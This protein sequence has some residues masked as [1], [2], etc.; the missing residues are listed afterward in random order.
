MCPAEVF[1]RY[2]FAANSGPQ[3]V[4][5]NNDAVVVG[6]DEGLTAITAMT[7][8][9][10]G[11]CA[12]FLV[13]GSVGTW[14]TGINDLDHVV[15]FYW[16]ATGNP[17]EP[18]LLRFH[19]FLRDA[20]GIVR[21]D[22]PGPHDVVFPTG[23][24]DVGQIVGYLYSD[25]QPDNSYVYHAFRYENGTY[26]IVDDPSGADVWLLGLNN[27]GQAVGIVGSDGVTGGQAFLLDNGVFLPLNVPTATTVSFQP[28]AINDHGQLVGN[29]AERDMTGRLTFHQ[30]MA[31]PD[32]QGRGQEMQHV[33]KGITRALAAIEKNVR[34]HIQSPRFHG[35]L[36]QFSPELDVDGAVV[37]RRGEQVLGRVH[38]EGKK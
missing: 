18:G 3:V 2:P 22:G 17:D 5:M 28:T 29:Y 23:L 12:F 21:L 10:D 8:T 7:Q 34:R 13:P 37:L 30:F 6:N 27:V 33:P 24:N 26:E 1:Q 31:T 20:G 9:P 19:G 11:T 4:G 36:Q 35:L 16:N 25:V 38:Q 32:Q 15:G 14:A